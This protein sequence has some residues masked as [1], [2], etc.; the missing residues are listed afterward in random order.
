MR[1]AGCSSRSASPWASPRVQPDPSLFARIGPGRR[2]G[3]GERL[4]VSARIE[5]SFAPGALELVETGTAVALRFTALVATRPESSLSGRRARSAT[6]CVRAST[7]CPSTAARRRPSWIRK[8]RGP[9]PPSSAPS[10]SVPRRR[11]RTGTRVIVRAEIGIIDSSGAW[12]DAP[13]LWNYYG[14]RAVLV[15]GSCARPERA[16]GR[17]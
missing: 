14:P 13:V 7:R 15:A 5:N 10:S 4:V 16:A 2:R 1:S 8:P 11:R 17:K 6:T 9:W 3:P 12:H